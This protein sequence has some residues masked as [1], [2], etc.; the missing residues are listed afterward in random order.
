MTYSSATTTCISASLNA[1]KSHTASGLGATTKT[2]QSTLASY[3]GA[4]D[5]NYAANSFGILALAAAALLL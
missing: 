3:T 5:I 1:T 2:T 4:A